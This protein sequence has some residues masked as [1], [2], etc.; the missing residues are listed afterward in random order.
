MS[1]VCL[2]RS[3]GDDYAKI[4]FSAESRLSLSSINAFN[5]TFKVNASSRLDFAE[6][7]FVKTDWKK[8]NRLRHRVNKA[9]N[10]QRNR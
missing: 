6:R 8:E 5:S 2:L 3:G 10:I 4:G 7:E 9:I 1:R